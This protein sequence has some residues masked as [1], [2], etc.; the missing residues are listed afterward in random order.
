MPY[1]NT[2]KGVLFA[3]D[4]RGNEKA[5][6]YKG[7]IDIN[8]VEKEIAGWV[9]NSAKGELISLVVQEPRAKTIAPPETSN[10]EIPNEDL[11]F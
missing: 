5:P 3:N 8:G 4:K 6:D 1:D 11:P 7:K 10:E 2:N 9:R